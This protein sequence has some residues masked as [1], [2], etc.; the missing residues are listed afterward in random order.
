M[1]KS[2]KRKWQKYSSMNIENT[3]LISIAQKNLMISYYQLEDNKLPSINDVGFSNYS[4]SDEDGILLYIFSLIKFDSKIVV[5]IGAGGSLT[6]SNAANLIIHH[7]FHGL[8]I[9]G[10]EKR[11]N[12]V[13]Q[14]FQHHPLTKGFPPKYINQLLS[15]TN[16]NSIIESA[17][18]KGIIDL[19]LIDIDSID[20]WIWECLEVIQPR[21]VVIEVQCIWKAD[22]S[23][24]VPKDF[25]GSVFDGQYGIYNS[26]SL[27]AFEKLA[28]QK[29]YRLIG[30]HKDGF[31]AFFIKEDLAV[32][33]LPTHSVEECLDKPFVHWANQKFEK[34]IKEYKWVTV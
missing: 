11:L 3:S 27:K 6:G 4:E 10:N 29:G 19:L 1:L 21:V 25:T 32:N 15:T 7:G 14:A 23:V 34:K 30:T 20:Y 22:K 33:Q 16:V 8:L 24:S 26:A 28:K 5:D 31:N 17:G 12:K 9:E 13:R 2:I 18:F